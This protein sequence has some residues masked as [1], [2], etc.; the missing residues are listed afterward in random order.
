MAIVNL[1]FVDLVA[2][3][4]SQ[5]TTQIIGSA[6]T[7][8]RSHTQVRAEPNKL[9]AVNENYRVKQGEATFRLFSQLNAD[10]DPHVRFFV[11]ALLL[12]ATNEGQRSLIAS[13][14]LV[15]NNNIIAGKKYFVDIDLGAL[16]INWTPE[17]EYRFE[18]GDDFVRDQGVDDVET[19]AAEFTLDYTS[20]PPVAI[21]ESNPVVFDNNVKNN[22]FIEIEFDRQVRPNFVGGNIYLY[23]D[24]DTLVSTYDIKQD[25]EFIGFDK[26]KFSTL[27]KLKSNTTYYLLTDEGV[28]KDYDNLS[29]DITDENTFRFTTSLFDFP[30]LISFK[31]V[32]A[33]L[34][35]D[36][37]RYRDYSSN[38]NVL[39]Q[40]GT[41]AIV[42]GNVVFTDVVVETFKGIIDEIYPVVTDQQTD[43]VKTARTVKTFDTTASAVI[44]ATYVGS[45]SGSYQSVS[46]I[47]GRMTY[48][49]GG[50]AKQLNVSANIA[51]NA[52]KT[53]RTVKTLN[54]VATV[55]AKN[56]GIFR[57]ARTLFGRFTSLFDTTPTTANFIDP[58]SNTIKYFDITFTRI[59]Y[60]E[61]PTST[62]IPNLVVSGFGDN[63]IGR[64][65]VPQLAGNS[66]DA[67]QIPSGFA[68]N[69]NYAIMSTTMEQFNTPLWFNG[70]LYIFNLNDG[71]LFRTI[72]TPVSS[73]PNNPNTFYFGTSLDHDG[74]N[75]IASQVN[76]TGT[77][78]DTS[79][80][81]SAKIYSISTGNL[82]RSITLTNS[83][84]SNFVNKYPR[85][86]V[87]GDYA[88][89][90]V[91]EEPR[92][93]GFGRIYVYSI[94]SGDLLYT[95]NQ[96]GYEISAD[97]NILLVSRA[98]LENT[99]VLVYDLTTGTLT[100]TITNPNG[101]SGTTAL[102]SFGKSIDIAS[103]RIVIAAPDEGLTGNKGRVYVYNLQGTLLATITN[104]RQP[105]SSFAQKIKFH[106]RRLF[107]DGRDIFIP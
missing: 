84:D 13:S 63:V 77:P 34:V 7:D 55:N 9:Y 83:Y 33:Q 95:I 26:I 16:G 106:D 20:N 59:A 101:G 81:F 27:G 35:L 54:A 58:N 107:V 71:S 38:L 48:N 42:D 51:P 18:F 49:R 93:P 15:C 75:I 89:I 65:P 74:D 87:N 50:L 22:T 40:F 64:T 45:G 62:P 92:N 90:S 103:D 47:S 56:N 80:V 73:D 17:T 79:Y 91:P 19:A 5:T 10:Y 23:E 98:T 99:S 78:Q 100:T 4:D 1:D 105:S 12:T 61:Q 70:A 97:Q 44:N 82:V 29:F 96:A 6:T 85:V 52:V 32:N 31:F 76:T 14:N 60:V 25:I 3:T 66:P 104:R 102:D 69:P 46:N 86:A 24:P 67:R 2:Y 43:A 37:I 88:V 8:W 94:S 53:A 39:T 28:I 57:I 72:T 30:E 68:I 36:Y 11:Q 21:E 41:F